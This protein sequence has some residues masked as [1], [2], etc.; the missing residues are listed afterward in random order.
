MLLSGEKLFLRALEPED[1]AEMAKIENY[2]GFWDSTNTNVPYSRYFL[3][4]FI[5]DTTGDIYK[6]GQLRLVAAEKKTETSVAFVDLSN[7]DPR[8]MRA[9][10]GI[11]VFPDYQHIGYGTE[12][13][14]LL[15][16][17]AYRQL[18]MHTLYAVAAESNTASLRLLPKAGYRDCCI[19]T[20]WLALP[21]GEFANAVLFQKTLL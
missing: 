10:I 17:Y 19:L 16:E 12:I 3:R 14:S 6:D 7:F 11:L 1:L 8:N 9:E 13:L 20:D 2:T 18:L 5:E 4:R 21:R 15:E